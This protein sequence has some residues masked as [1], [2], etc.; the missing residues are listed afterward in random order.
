M[1]LAAPVTSDTAQI[2]VDGTTYELPIVEGT[3]GERA[4]DI[5]RLRDA[6]GLVTLDP[7]YGNTGS[8]LS[9]IT[10]IDGEEGILRYRGYSIGELAERSTFLETAYLLLKGELPTAEQ[11]S[12]FQE[13][14]TYHT[15]VHEDLR[16]MYRAFPHDAHPMA[17]TSAV[18][19]ALSTFYQDSLDPLDDEQVELSTDRLLGKL[20]TICSWAFKYSIGQAFNYPRNDLS[21]AENLLHM[22]FATPA[23][24]YELNP[25]FARALEMMLILH[26]DHEQNCSSSTMRLVGSSHANIYS[27]A[28]AAINAL[29]G[30][31]HGGANE[32]VI[33][34]L[35]DIAATEGS[36]RTFLE[37]AK[38]RDDTTRLMGFGH[39]VY[40]HY[41]P[42]A[43]ILKQMTGEVLEQLHRPTQLLEIAMELEEVALNDDYF[44]SRKL[45]PNVDFYS[46]IIYEALGFP[47]DMFTVFFALGRMPGWIAQWTEQHH[48]PAERL[49]RPRQI[50]VGEKERSYVPIEER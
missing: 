28:A 49:G 14:I 29:W 10:F 35:H 32:A 15:L 5:S 48:D 17:V 36:G 42:R 20:P 13:R 12:E 16:Q 37:R 9:A 47:T 31:R 46:G 24:E 43:A 50:Y 25:T 40:K 11:L 2:T 8:C 30:P 6:T 3:E 26:A 22:M 33:E 41:D 44:V 38:D 27:S 23:E 39:R 18:V 21:Y 7:G 1:T 19:G 45:Y 34:M 4:V